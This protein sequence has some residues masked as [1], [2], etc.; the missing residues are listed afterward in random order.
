MNAPAGRLLN[1]Q[2]VRMMRLIEAIQDDNDSDGTWNE[3]H[4]LLLSLAVRTGQEFAYKLADLVCELRER[5]TPSNNGEAPEE[6]PEDP[7]W[8]YGFKQGMQDA[9]T[10][11]KTALAAQVDEVE[12]LVNTFNGVRLAQELRDWIETERSA[13][14]VA[15][16]PKADA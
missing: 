1:P 14:R 6:N 8:D 5:I 2:N 9:E 4:T 16:K 15:A 10:D 3:L 12:T 7:Q 11:Q 13:P